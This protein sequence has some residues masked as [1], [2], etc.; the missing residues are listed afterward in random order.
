MKHISFHLLCICLAIHFTAYSQDEQSSSD[1]AAEM[2]RKLQDPLANI[3]A[4]FSDNDL[5]FKTG[6]D[7]FSFSSS[8]Q[9]VFAW[10]FDDA[11]FNFIA[12]GLFPIMG[13]APE[14]Q[15][16][17]IGPPLPSGESDTWGLGDITT[18][19]FFSPKT[20][21][22]WKWGGGPMVSWRTRTDSKL[23]G[24]G[25]GAGP[26]LI[27]VGGAGDFGFAFIGGQMWGFDGNFSTAMFQPMIFYNVPTVPGLAISYNNQ[28]AYNWQATSGNEFTLPLGLG[29]SK[30]FAFPSGNALDLGVG[31]Y[32]NAVRP[33]G[34]ASFILRFNVAWVFP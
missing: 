8:I 9:P 2:A 12:R 26:V 28:W 34:A 23:A 11:G 24:A 25:W 16:P 6:Q 18:Q 30:T 4:I 29:V 10:S 20:E 1:A 33:E 32:F 17:I 31:P 19:F 21:G 7:D 27:L 5:L 15:R 22:A 14:A 3:R 13:L